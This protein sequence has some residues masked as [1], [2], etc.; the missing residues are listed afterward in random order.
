MHIQCHQMQMLLISLK[1]LP[2]ASWMPI[3]PNKQIARLHPRH[4][5]PEAID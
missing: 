3:I 4:D 1:Q 5:V 2:T